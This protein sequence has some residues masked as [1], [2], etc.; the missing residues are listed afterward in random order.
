MI[1][2]FLF[3][4]FFSFLFGGHFIW[5]L[6]INAFGLYCINLGGFQHTNYIIFRNAEI[7]TNYFS[8]KTKIFGEGKSRIFW[9]VLKKKINFF[10]KWNLQI[11]LIIGYTCAEATLVL[12]IFTEYSKNLLN[13]WRS[14]F[15]HDLGFL[16]SPF[17]L[18]MSPSVINNLLQFIECFATYNWKIMHF[19]FGKM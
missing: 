12:Q 16:A 18:L 10:W 7:F 5:A 13:F 2:F 19:I 14:C 6:N 8:Q 3:S 17:S 9:N 4:F 11:Q 1:R 15:S